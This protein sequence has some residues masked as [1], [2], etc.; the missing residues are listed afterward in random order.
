MYMCCHLVNVFADLLWCCCCCWHMLC[1]VNECMRCSLNDC[2]FIQWLFVFSA[3]SSSW[4]CN[5][6]DCVA[7]KEATWCLIIT[8]ASVDWLSKFFHQLIREKILYTCAQRLPPHLQYVAT[9]PCESWKSKN[10]TD[11]D[12]I[13]NKL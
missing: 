1:F 10:V 4:S 2:L 13:L 9:L 8:L 6:V 3:I 7:K 5:I 11:F 12:S